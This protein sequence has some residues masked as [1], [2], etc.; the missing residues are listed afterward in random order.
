MKQQ[1]ETMERHNHQLVSTL[2]N[3]EKEIRRLND[4]IYD[5][6]GKIESLNSQIKS[7]G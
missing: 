5:L 2:I 3:K 4:E 1:L 6:M 7:L